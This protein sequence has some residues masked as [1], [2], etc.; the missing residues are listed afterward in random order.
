MTSGIIGNGK[1][2]SCR[3]EI[4]VKKNKSNVIFYKEETER[5]REN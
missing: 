2:T 3:G 5:Q 4:N 1:V